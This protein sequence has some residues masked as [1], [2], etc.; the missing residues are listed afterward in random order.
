[1]DTE[2]L[3]HLIRNHVQAKGKIDARL[4]TADDTQIDL[5]LDLLMK[6]VLMNNHK[7]VFKN[8]QQDLQLQEIMNQIQSISKRDYQQFYLENSLILFKEKIDLILKDLQDRA[9]G[10]DSV[11]K[12]FQINQDLLSNYTYF[13]ADA[14]QEGSVLMEMILEVLGG[15]SKGKS[16]SPDLQEYFTKLC[17]FAE[18]IMNVFQAFY[19]ISLEEIN[20]GQ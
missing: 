12:S 19:K 18:R 3:L 6:K 10:L 11:E 17:F 7:I 8:Q 9:V 16:K 13:I 15:F 4:F 1:M 5:L 14:Y 2:R 20:L